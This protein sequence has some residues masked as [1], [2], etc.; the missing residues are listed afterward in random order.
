MVKPVGVL[1]RELPGGLI[2]LS[3][4]PSL[5]SRYTWLLHF[6]GKV[7]YHS[8]FP[9]P[10]K[11]WNTTKVLRQYYESILELIQFSYTGLPNKPILHALRYVLKKV[12][13]F[14]P[15]LANFTWLLF[16]E[17]GVFMDFV[18]QK[19]LGMVP[20]S[21]LYLKNVEDTT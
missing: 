10:C 20:S 7:V 11:Y 4:A 8:T 16:L 1:R 2:H 14:N 6:H 18:W 12:N 9:L 15:C 13:G 3:K 5:F 19:S 21:R 17:Y